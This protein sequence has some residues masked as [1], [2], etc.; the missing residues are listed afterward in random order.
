MTPRKSAQNTEGKERQAISFCSNENQRKLR[1]KT[2]TLRQHYLMETNKHQRTQSYS[3]NRA[4]Y[5]KYAVALSV[6]FL[7]LHGANITTN[8]PA[9][10]M[11]GGEVEMK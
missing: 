8:Q 11:K 3:H 2:T 4:V 1:I 6:F 5:Q 9:P 10:G 7:V